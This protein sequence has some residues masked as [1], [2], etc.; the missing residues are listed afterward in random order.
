MATVVKSFSVEGIEG[1]GIEIEAVTIKGMQQMVSI[2]GLGDQAV[3]EAGERIQAALDFCGYD[4]PKDKTIISLAPG[5]RR[6]RGSHYDLAMAI[7]LLQQTDQISAKDLSVVGLIGE[8]SLNGRLRACNGI[9][10]MVSEAKRM[11]ISEV[12]IPYANR[13]TEFCSCL[14]CKLDTNKIQFS[15][16]KGINMMYNS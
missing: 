8:L 7:A 3:K 14:I 15:V 5:D 9:L 1:F 4:M 2:I 12:I 11:G 6:K 16:A 10:P 13:I